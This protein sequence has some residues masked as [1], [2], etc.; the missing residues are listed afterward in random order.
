MHFIL[1]FFSAFIL[2]Q[3]KNSKEY[4]K[5]KERHRETAYSHKKD[6]WILFSKYGNL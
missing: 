4:R 1:D 2:N 3:M 5:Q 6:H